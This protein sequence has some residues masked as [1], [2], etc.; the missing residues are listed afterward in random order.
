MPGDRPLRLAATLCLALMTLQ[1]GGCKSVAPDAAP[2]VVP[3]PPVSLDRKVGWILRL[4]QQRVLRDPGVTPTPFDPSVSRESSLAP[5]SAPDL[6]QLALDPDAAVRARAA[7]AIGRV[8][9]PEGRRDLEA[10][11]RDADP[12]VRASAAFALGLLGVKEAVPALETALADADP[13]VRGAAIEALGLIGDPATVAAVERAAA[14]CAGLIA[15]IE[16]DDEAWPKSPEIEICRL[17]LFALVR[18]HSYDGIARLVLD[19]QGRPVSRWWPV[20]YALQRIGDPR[21]GPTLL[22]LAST[23]GVDTAGFA[24]RG[25]AALKVADAAPLARALV[26][27]RGADVK[28]RIAAVRALAQLGVATDAAVLTQVLNE[29]PLAS[30]LGLELIAALGALRQPASFDVVVDTLTERSPAVRAAALAAAAHIN[31]DSFL[32]ILAGLGRDRD[33]T[34]RAAL[35]PVLAT[36]PADRVTSAVVALT[37]DEDPRV[38]GP[39]LEALAALK[40]PDLRDRLVTALS[41]PDFVE[42]ATAARL[43]G[44]LKI[45]GGVPLL[46]AAYTR[47]QSDTAYGARAAAV[48]ALARFGGA[49]AMATIRTALTDREW[50]VRLKAADLLRGLGEPAAS[51]ARPAP[52]RITADAFEAPA[53][54]HPTYS[55]HALIDTR[56]G[57]IEVQLDVVDATLT[58]RTFIEQARAGFF[59]G[60]RVH[61]VVPTFVVQDG[62]PRGDGEGGPGYSVRDEISRDPFVRGTLGMALDGRDTGGSQWF[63]TLTPQPH[64]DAKY[65]AFG[66][67]VA[68]WDVLDKLAPWDVIERIR[69]WDGVELR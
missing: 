10:A 28:L 47:G 69:I 5:A 26:T 19:A 3:L 15:P 22:A 37:E 65:T 16:S 53:L 20:A 33:W 48:E 29:T 41:A 68:G 21:A 55:P 58:A 57:V 6:A 40:A 66:R 38:H 36:L 61:R 1:I 64:L 23:P 67:V 45:E 2:A 34:V 8:G 18:L 25:L 43:I 39:A 12:P 51:P 44:A 63:I 27:R 11:L 14:G 24:L 17:S 35:A 54:L 9:M 56:Y 42:R 60:L 46:V 7:L 32:L 30:P 62:D 50:P 4:E 49:E 59:T 31:P 13:R 52:L